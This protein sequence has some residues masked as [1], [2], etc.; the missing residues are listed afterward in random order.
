[1]SHLQS[2]GSN[3]QFGHITLPQPIQVLVL[4]LHA[5]CLQS[6]IVY[7]LYFNSVMHLI[8]RYQYS[9]QLRGHYL[10]LQSFK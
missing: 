9:R 1:L 7:Y 3:K 10:N 5:Q 2:D 6:F 8:I 4:R